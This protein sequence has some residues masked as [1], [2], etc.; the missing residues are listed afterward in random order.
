MPAACEYANIGFAMH[1]PWDLGIYTAVLLHLAASTPNLTYSNDYFGTWISGDVI[2]GGYI[3][4]IDGYCHV[5]N[6]AG[7]GCRFGPRRD[8]GVQGH[9][10]EQMV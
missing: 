9:S 7:S 3:P 2:K 4:V 1:P 5:P 8:D 10:Q 6:V